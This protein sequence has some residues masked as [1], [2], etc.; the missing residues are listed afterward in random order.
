LPWAVEERD[1]ATQKPTACW[2]FSSR[3]LGVG[4]ACGVVDGDVT[5]SQPTVLRR[6]PSASVTLRLCGVCAAEDRACRAALD[7]PELLDVDV[8]QLARRAR[9]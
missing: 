8:D 4:Q 6:C 5:L 9:S 3:A 1:G 2:P 7:A